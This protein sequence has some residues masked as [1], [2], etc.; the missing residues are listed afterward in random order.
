MT[1]LPNKPDAANPATTLWSTIEDQW[2][3]VAEITGVSQIVVL[4]ALP[5]T[6][7]KYVS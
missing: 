3:R 6:A 2:R 5:A 1:V 7:A 4:K